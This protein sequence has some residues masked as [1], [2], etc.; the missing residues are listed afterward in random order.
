M[1]TRKVV[2]LAVLAL[3]AAVPTALASNTWY[4]DGVDG[5]DNNDCESSQTA[6]KT[7]GRAM[8][9]SGRGD[10]IMVSA[11]TYHENLTIPHRLNI[12]GAGATT[13]I[14]D[15]GGVGSVILNNR[16]GV[17]VSRVTMRNG[18]GDLGGGVGDGGNVYNCFA[19]LT[20]MD[21]IITGGRVRSAPG[22]DGYGGAIYNCPG[23]TLTLINTTISG[24]SAEEGGGICNGGNLT[25]I[26]ST[27]S[28][29]IARHRKGGGIRNYGTLRIT[30]TT[31][32]GNRAS[33]VGGGIHNGGLFGPS[34]TMVISNS[35]LS[36]NIAGKGQGGGIFSNTNGTKTVLQNSIVASN[37]GSDCSGIMTSHGYNLT[38]DDSCRLNA[39][40]DVENANP[41]LGPL[42][43]N[44]GFTRT[45]ALLPGSPAIDSGN[46][47]G[48][49]DGDGE[50]LKTD[51]RG[52]PRPDKDDSGACDTG[53]YE[54]QKD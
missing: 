34:G 4:V 22:F 31:I 27:F 14:I 29:N 38:S 33:G 5:S 24:N 19:S 52:E 25:I 48:C 43:D 41:N 26:N 46:P 42:Q 39:A 11:A 1:K 35:T 53:A 12:V 8:S 2:C 36:G 9:H 49:T 51:Q 47:S 40:G 37:E 10:F 28:G 7:I 15:G 23:S 44:G 3:F 16:T 17:T 45:M 50:L 13:T 21:S 6:C 54:R 18:G 20:I 32:S 30:N